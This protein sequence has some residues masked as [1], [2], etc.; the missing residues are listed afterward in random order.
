VFVLLRGY[1]DESVDKK[2]NIF[3]LACLISTL[4]E[5]KELERAWKIY[6]AGWNKRLTKLH[7]PL[8]TRYHA[9]DTFTGKSYRK[10]FPYG[11]PQMKSGRSSPA[12]SMKQSRRE[13]LYQPP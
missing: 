13:W 5:W 8:I 1:I 2:Q 9:S 3:T 11:I 7:R 4:K 6:L 12:A 10:G